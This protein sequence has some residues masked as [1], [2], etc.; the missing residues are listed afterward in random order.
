MGRPHGWGVLSFP[1]LYGG[2]GDEA[3]N[4]LESQLAAARE[5]GWK[6]IEAR[7]ITLP[8][9]PK[10]NLHDLPDAAFDEVEQALQA[11]GVSVYCFASTIG[12]WSKNVED[13][14]DITLA[15]VERAIPRLQRLGSLYIRVM[16]YKV[17]EGA[18]L[19]EEDRFRRSV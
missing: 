14:F 16:I 13:S 4:L 9:F 17:R 19:M 2:I 12:N 3:G 15:E 8:G 5:L 10:A 1:S 7:N 6:H 11:A 18:D